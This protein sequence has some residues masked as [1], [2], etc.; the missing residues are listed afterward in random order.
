MKKKI[1]F[2]FL[3]IKNANKKIINTFFIWEKEE[4]AI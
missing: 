2:L 3:V 1:K 4:I